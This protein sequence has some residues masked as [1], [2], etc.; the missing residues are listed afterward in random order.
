MLSR[1]IE[2]FIKHSAITNWIMIVILIA[3]VFGLTNL[4]KRLD[5]KFELEQIEVDVPFPGA[6]AIE[7]EEGIVIKIE[8]NLR[9]I[10]GIEKVTSNSMDNYGSVSVEITPG[11][12]MNKAIQDI[13]NSVNSINSYPTGAEKPVV[14]QRTQWNRA[15]MLSIYGPSDLFTLKKIVEEFRDDLLKTGKISNIMTWG[16]PERE[17]SVEISPENLIRYKLTIDE[18]ATAIR[19]SNLN[20][21]SGS[22]LTD[23]EQILI[24]SY[25]RKYEALDLEDIEIVSTISGRKIKLRDICTV[26][27]QWPENRF[28]SEYN[29]KRSVGFNV[30]YNNNEDVLEID[31][32]TT[33]IAKEYEEK[34]AGLVQFN[35]FIKEVD[36]L[37]ERIDLL[38][39]N[40]IIGLVLVLVILSVFLNTR[41]S[42]WVALGIPISL[43]GMFFVLWALDISI[44]QFSL[45]GMIMVIGILV[46]D[47]II[48]G[49]SIYSQVEKYGKSP[50]RAAID[51][52]LDVIKP[53]TI[54]IFT[55]IV[56]FLPYF[57]F[58][59]MLGKYVWQ[60]AAV[61]II[62]LLF[63][64][65]E[66]LIILPTHLAHSKALNLEKKEVNFFTRFRARL[67]K[68]LDFF[69]DT[70][71]SKILKFCLKNRWAVSATVI[72]V[73][74]LIVG[75][76]EGSHVRAQ[77]FPEIE[78]PYSRIQVEVPAGMSAIVADGIRNKMIDKTLAFGEKFMEEKGEPLNPIQNFTSWMNGGT[79]NIFF[80]LPSSAQ[81]NYDVGDFSDALAEYIGE[82]PEAENIIIGGWSF[83]GSPISVRFSSTDYTQLMNA[84]DLVKAELR[85]ID[86]IKDI[87]DDTPLG[88]NEFIIDLKPKG[89]A[90]GF[91]LR[92]LTS[93]LRQG[94]YG[95]EVMRLQKGRDEV[96]IWV[97]F[98]KDDRMS[99][100][101][102]ENLKVRTPM[103]EFVPFK[104]VADYQI[105]RSIRRIR[106]EDGQ[107]SLTV[108]ANLDYSKNDLAVIL[109][110]LDEVVIPKVLSQ[111]EGVQRNYGGQSEE[112][113]KMVGS[114]TYS[115][116][117]ALVVMF[118]ILMFLLKS[119]M[120]TLLIM[121]LIPLGIIGAV[122][123]HYIIGIPISILSFLGIVALAGII[124]N[125]SVVLVDRF[126]KLIANGVE[127]S[128]A[129]FEA[130]MSRF[131]PILLTTIT[132][133]AG[134]API[135]L[136]TSEQGQFLVP[137]AVSV[138]FGLLFGTFLTLLMLPS[139]LYVISDMRKLI[140]RKKSRLEI[141]PA[142]K[143]S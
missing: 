98:S 54:S 93:Q 102:I 36:E 112:V 17:I 132:T 46:D 19:N 63:S 13:K 43:L 37:Q 15:I 59:G 68:V 108:Y 110:E 101:Q 4:N 25:N 56:A 82:V 40:G 64:L 80:V 124:I 67:D 1:F 58:Y 78:P 107:R 123:G 140:Y 97:R 12:D 113:T 120:Q 14:Y 84:K 23:Q 24:R 134:L 100:A 115:M 76:F 69:L 10:E 104:E 48:I 32:I 125:D 31:E 128:E 111:V 28:Y 131:R 62:S 114:M 30:M 29:G 135:I 141:E 6:S 33:R 117:I 90:L 106:H 77:F 121:G 116:T 99:I 49:E 138:A 129:L 51:G 20:I 61:V 81:R 94:F 92:D 70:V 35:T 89:K 109:K 45:F 127:I 119:Y 27:E 136:L 88:N 143:K 142:F 39:Q 38:T 8:E 7:V 95:Q 9:G 103:G 65:I 22:V 83:G 85:Q 74:L 16:L 71:Y 53:V 5:P 105:Q 130:G 47:G 41:L 139:A 11:H 87:R 126:N 118:T 133:S 44:N 18:I 96:K 26:Q 55:T 91:T 57:Y 52:T 137:M 79:I 75:L 122:I 86:G 73:V 72:A 2:Y 66:A 60:I 34:Y 21:S 50:L 3:G 42:F